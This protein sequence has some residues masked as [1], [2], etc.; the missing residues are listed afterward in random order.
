MNTRSIPA[1]SLR[2]CLADLRRYVR[3]IE[4]SR[5]PEYAQAAAAA[6]LDCTLE[7]RLRRGEL[8]RSRPAE[9]SEQAEAAA[10]R[11]GPG[12]ED[13]IT[14]EMWARQRDAEDTCRRQG[15]DIVDCSSAGPDSGNMDHECRRCGQYWPV[16][17][18]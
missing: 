9:L 12:P 1:P 15:H 6:L 16:P 10:N 18:Y 2:H 5:N 11:G 17:L 7:F 4:D 8:V 13:E 14:D 3:E